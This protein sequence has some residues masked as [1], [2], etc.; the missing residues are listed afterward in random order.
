MLVKIT[1]EAMLELPD[2]TRLPYLPD[3][4][5]AFTLPDGDWIKPWIVLERND[6]DDLRFTELAP[7]GLDLEETNITVEAAGWAARAARGEQA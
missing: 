1:L 7:L 2:G 6:L 5:R 3:D 4:G